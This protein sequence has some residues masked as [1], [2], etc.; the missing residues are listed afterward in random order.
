MTTISMFELEIV[1]G[2]EGEPTPTKATYG[3]A[4]VR[5][6]VDGAIA[7]ASSG[8]GMLPFAAMSGPLTPA[9]VATFVGIGAGSGAAIGC[10]QGMWELRKAR[11]P[12]QP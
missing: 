4:C 11:R 8:A 10:A 6:A 9:T 3:Q 5:G 12:L 1:M 2:G 7:G